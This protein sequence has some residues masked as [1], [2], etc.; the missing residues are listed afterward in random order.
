MLFSIDQD[1]NSILSLFDLLFTF[2]AINHAVF[3]NI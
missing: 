2:D 3:L 1:E